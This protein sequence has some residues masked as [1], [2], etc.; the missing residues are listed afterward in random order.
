MPE[1][2]DP[3][4]GTTQ[5][6]RNSTPHANLP[7]PQ[8]QPH[9]DNQIL[10][11]KRQPEPQHGRDAPRPR[12][13]NRPVGVQASDSDGVMSCSLMR[14]ISLTVSMFQR[15]CQARRVGRANP[16]ATVTAFNYG[17]IHYSR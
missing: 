7:K 8:H 14:S 2:G 13:G 12:F 4:R 3:P 15:V 16:I 6:H 11:L 5:E 10:T 1:C 17:Y 9:Q